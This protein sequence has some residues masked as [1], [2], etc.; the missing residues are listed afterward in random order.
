[1]YLPAQPHLPVQLL[2]AC[3]NNTSATYKY[4]WF[5]SLL[6]C[7]EQ[8]ETQ[9]PKHRLFAGMVANAWYT[10]NYFHVSFGKQDQL[11]RAIHEIKA[12]ENLP[13]DAS[14]E[15]IFNA[16]AQS[17]SKATLSQLRYFN[18][19]V[20]HRFLSPWFSGT[21]KNA[22]YRASQQFEGNCLYG[23]YADHLEVNPAWVPYLQAH[24]RVLK[25]YCSWNLAVYLQA[26]N[27]NVP[28]IPNK[29]SRPLLRNTLQRQRKEFWDVVLR[30]LG[31]VSCIYSG[32][33]LTVGDYAVE[34]FIPYSFV[35]HDLVWNL[36]PADR[37]FNS[38]KSDK[39]PPLDRYFDAFYDI[40]QAAI[41]VFHTQNISSPFLDDY[42]TLFSTI[43]STNGGLGGFTKC[44]FRERLEPLITIAA[45]N[46]FEF[47]S[48]TP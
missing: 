38:T 12:V 45:N 33:T 24:A 41:Q 29:L 8:G 43:D 23:L 48:V 34:H 42:L 27:P 20:P 46:G 3:F 9:I 14:Q 1:M 6:Q 13:V 19:E 30:H 21:E 26:K 11:Q 16:L 39:L 31:S 10:V 47:L 44:G 28:G 40:Q 4:Y 25:D 35:T 5:L 15:Y 36:I 17:T 18:G 2:A 7:V 37:S 32:R 22:V